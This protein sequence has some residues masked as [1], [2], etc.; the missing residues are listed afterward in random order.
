MID[1][2]DTKQIA[3][4]LAAV[5]VVAAIGRAPEAAADG[6]GRTG[7]AIAASV[8]RARKR[9]PPNTNANHPATLS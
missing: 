8:S 9:A 4:V 7:P 6:A 2:N 5:A 1:A 3:P